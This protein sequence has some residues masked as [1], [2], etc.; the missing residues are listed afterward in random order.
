[1]HGR[2]TG[3]ARWLAAA[4]LLLL[5]GCQSALLDPRGPVGR[6]EKIILTNSVAIMLAIVVPTIIATLAFAWWFRAS[7]KR[8]T[9]LPDW[10]FSGRIELVVW[11]IP[12]MVILLLGGVTWISS[13]Q[14]DPARP[15]ESDVKPLDIQVVSLDW[16][17]LFIYPQQGV[18]AVNELVVPAGV[19]L[20]FT[21]TSASVL[22]T[23][24][25]PQL[26][27]MIY[28]MNGMATELHLHADEPG[29][30]L[31]LSGHFSGDGFSDMNFQV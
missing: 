24:F 15:L 20:H 29:S 6:A 11:S 9:Y 3:P 21:L 13:Q 30:Y 16:K 25:V 4:A 5:G 26:G 19:P 27:S 2:M 23:F 18:A 1:M 12:I 28:T 7:N 22:N 10:E 14:L 31:G 17:W 8:A